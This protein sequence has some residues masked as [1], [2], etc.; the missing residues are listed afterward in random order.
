MGLLEKLKNALFEEDEE[1]ED[2]R[3]IKRETKEKVSFPEEEIV[4]KID[5]NKVSKEEYTPMKNDVSSFQIQ[6]FKIEERPKGPIIFDDED[7]LSD[8]K[9][10]TFKEVPKKE[11]KILYGGYEAKEEIKTKEKFKPSPI[12]SPVYGVVEKSFSS[13]ERISS[14]KRVVDHLFVEEAKKELTFDTIRQKAFGGP[15]KEEAVDDNPLLY[16]MQ[17]HDEKPGIEK[18]TLGDAEEYFED[19]GLEYEVD[20]KDIAKANMTRRKKNIDI[21]ELLNEELNEET[22]IDEELKT[23][24]KQK[25]VTPDIFVDYLDN[26]AEEKNLYDLIDMMYESK[27]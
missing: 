22:Q 15:I 3:E 7:F 11:E 10:L 9:E 6:E 27:E 5:V 24:R 21:T 17:D 20:Y 13:K 25:T 12:I 23:L 26:D 8:T 19:L 1:E 14:D 16:E 2:I 4:K 18:I